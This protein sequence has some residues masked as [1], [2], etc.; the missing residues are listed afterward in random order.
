MRRSSISCRKNFWLCCAQC[1][2]TL[3][4]QETESLLPRTVWYIDVDPRGNMALQ[5]G[6]A[7]NFKARPWHSLSKSRNFAGR[8]AAELIALNMT[9]GTHKPK[10]PLELWCGQSKN[11]F[12]IWPLCLKSFKNNSW[13][14]IL[15]NPCTQSGGSAR[16]RRAITLSRDGPELSTATQ[17][18]VRLAVLCTWYSK[19]CRKNGERKRNGTK[20]TEFVPK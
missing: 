13:I 2:A 6:F 5:S 4:S 11:C 9:K 7:Y 20:H 16:V 19:I 3:S 1:A 14:E 8:S 15:L 18:G 17:S 10:K 12:K